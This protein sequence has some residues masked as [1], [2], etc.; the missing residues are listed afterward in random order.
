MANSI[1]AKLCCISTTLGDIL[2]SL[3]DIL[4]DKKE[5]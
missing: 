2:K 3:I 4:T 5:K 1:K